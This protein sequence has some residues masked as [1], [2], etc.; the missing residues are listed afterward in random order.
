METLDEQMTTEGEIV[1]NTS[2]IKDEKEQIIEIIHNTYEIYFTYGAT[3]SKKVDYFHN[4]IK[5]QLEVIFVDNKYNVLLERNVKSTNST[6]KKKCDIVVYKNNEPYI[7][8]PVK[9]IMTNYQQNKNNSWENLTGEL[10]H[11][12]WANEN[13]NIIPINIFMNKTPYLKKDKKISKF[14]NITY[15]DIKNYEILKEKNLAFDIINYIIDVTHI[16]N[17]N[18]VFDKVPTI[19]GFNVNTPYREFQQILESLV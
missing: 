13:I 11:L 2:V 6:G 16:N 4:Y 14:E 15:D 10:T 7:V 9:L 3:S 8:F 17:I 19:I 1:S 18:D 5:Q 12:K